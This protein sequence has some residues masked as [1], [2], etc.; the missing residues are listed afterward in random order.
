MKKIYYS[1]VKGEIKL[2]D[3]KGKFALLVTASAGAVIGAVLGVA[4]YY[5]GWLG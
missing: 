3:W 2:N 1:G 4:A 5:N